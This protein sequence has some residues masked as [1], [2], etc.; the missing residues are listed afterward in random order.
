[1]SGVLRPCVKQRF[2]LLPDSLGDR[3][4]R[5]RRTD[6]RTVCT[7]RTSVSRIQGQCLRVRPVPRYPETT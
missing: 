5:A 4:G 3:R 7:G 2:P 1:M 6:A